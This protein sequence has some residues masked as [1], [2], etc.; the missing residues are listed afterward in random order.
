VATPATPHTLTLM[1]EYVLATW[2]H[3]SAAKKLTI[4]LSSRAPLTIAQRSRIDEIGTICFAC[5]G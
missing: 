3:P 1:L 5:N 2:T 4:T